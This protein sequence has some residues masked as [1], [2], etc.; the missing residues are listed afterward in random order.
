MLKGISAYK[1]NGHRARP[2]GV[3]VSNDFLHLVGFRPT[4]L[5]NDNLFKTLNLSNT[6]IQILDAQ[7]PRHP[8]R[9]D[10]C[11]STP[12]QVD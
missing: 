6:P 7:L 2:V 10:T 4:H 11:P 12:H 1:P 5:S 8:V 3:L 9:I